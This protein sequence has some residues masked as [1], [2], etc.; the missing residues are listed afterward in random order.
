MSLSVTMLRVEYSSSCREKRMNRNEKW[1][2]QGGEEEHVIGRQGGRKE[3]EKALSAKRATGTFELGAVQVRVLHDGRVLDG[4]NRAWELE[5]KMQVTGGRR[6]IA[7]TIQY[8]IRNFVMCGGKVADSG[9]K[10][11]LWPDRRMPQ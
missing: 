9:G 1:N 2:G 11:L 5:R 7:P 4:N 10:A 3:A 8:T 6:R